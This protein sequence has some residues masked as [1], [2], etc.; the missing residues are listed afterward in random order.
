MVFNGNLGIYAMIKKITLYGL[1][2]VLFLNYG[3]VKQASP[4]PKV[5]LQTSFGN[6]VIELNQKAAPITVKN[7]LGYVE[8]GFYDGI[9]FHR[10][11]SGFMIQ[12]GQFNA[13]MQQKQAKAPIKNE[14]KISNTRGTVAM[15]KTP[16][17]PDSATC[18]FF[19][20]LDDNSENLDHQNGGFTVF[21]KVVEGMDVVDKIAAVKV[22]DIRLGNN[23]MEK[24][25]VEPIVIISATVVSQ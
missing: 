14:F 16:Y 3:C 21:G 8:S 6:I 24:V 22:A 11:Y 1:F 18:Q 9:I 19:I 20:N 4:G 10:V 23:I 5:K 7:F 2:A 13:Q 12:T 15:A 17:N 25:P